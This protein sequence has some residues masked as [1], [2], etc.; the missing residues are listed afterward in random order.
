[1]DNI[2]E[3]TRRT[4]FSGIQPTGSLHIGNYFGAISTWIQLQSDTSVNSIL[5][6]VDLHA[7]T[8]EY[9]KD[10]LHHN[11]MKTFATY[12]ASGLSD[13]S[14]IIFKQ[15]DVP[16]HAELAWLLSNVASMGQLNRMTQFKDKSPKNQGEAKIGLF[17]YPILMA[18]DILLYGTTHVPVGDDQKQHLE[19]ARDIAERF[20]R[21]Y[22]NILQIPQ[23]QSLIDTPIRIMS[24]KDGTKKMSKS[25]SSADSKINL[26]DTDEMIINKIMKAKTDADSSLIY[27]EIQHRP[28]IKNLVYIMG[29]LT[30]AMILTPVNQNIMIRTISDNNSK[31]IMHALAETHSQSI[32]AK[33]DF[34]SLF[35]KIS[36]QTIREKIICQH[37]DGLGFAKFKKDLSSL[38]CNI[39]GR[40]RDGDKDL[41]QGDT[42]SL[43]IGIDA[44]MNNPNLVNRLQDG[45]VRARSIAQKQIRKIKHAMGII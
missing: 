34:S 45:G 19:L 2:T 25:D 8:V 23:L 38:M 32:W 7:I 3:N 4:I 14:N 18:A 27:E 35:S 6:I 16:E 31:N 21:L 17:T 30:N 20:N 9:D 44:H 36:N 1:M 40:I 11:I 39:V 10:I 41:L 29:W 5:C 13:K 28:E 43:C 24:L 15:S 12:L 33:E 42:E 26:D 37:Y 22:G